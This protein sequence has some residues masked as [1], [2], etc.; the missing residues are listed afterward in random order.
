MKL[1]ESLD[2]KK[3]TIIGLGILVLLVLIFSLIFGLSISKNGENGQK[4][5]SVNVENYDYKIIINS[6][7]KKNKIKE[8]KVVIKK[9]EEEIYQNT[10]QREDG[11]NLYELDVKRIILEK[12]YG[13]YDV[14]MNYKSGFFDKEEK[15]T[16]IIDDVPSIKEAKIIEDYQNQKYGISIDRVPDSIGYR[17]I[18]SKNEIVKTK[19]F[20]PE[21]DTEKLEIDIT[22]MIKEL[23]VG[24]YDVQ[25]E[26]L[27]S[28]TVS[29]MPQF[30]TCTAKEY[31]AK[32]K[33]ELTK[34][35]IGNQ[36]LKI[37]KD[38]L[39]DS[40]TMDISSVSNTSKAIYSGSV[41][42]NTDL[43]KLIKEKGYTEGVYQIKITP[44]IKDQE[45]YMVDTD[46]EKSV[47]VLSAVDIT[48]DKVSIGSI[49]GADLPVIN[50]P[51]IVISNIDSTKYK[52]YVA[53][54]S[55]SITKIYE[56]IDENS[57]VLK[58]KDVR[59]S[60]GRYFLTDEEVEKIKSD[61]TIELSIYKEDKVNKERSYEVTKKMKKVLVESV[62]ST[63]SL[64][65]VE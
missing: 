7:L 58:F 5:L 53:I 33:V 4:I 44:V 43:T 8:Y 15:Y 34:T 1:L 17:V 12:G 22:E 62:I 37:T 54:K 2:K 6:G 45:F 27:I 50:R 57:N 59:L 10:I 11:K 61:E 20:N 47:T 23:G 21:A 18:V 25:V 48:Y 26:N 9:S 31:I 65:I 28:E 32:P 51:W 56:Y 64:Q 13:S 52:Y 35:S 46:N 38:E 55:A 41:K 30:I 39:V 29:G 40:Y 19:D 60:G 49:G 36:I 63:E 16:F 24:K 42:D 14:T 3:I